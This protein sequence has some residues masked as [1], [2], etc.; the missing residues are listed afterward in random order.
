M[1]VSMKTLKILLVP[2]V[3]VV[4]LGG[5]RIA[6]GER[7]SGRG[8]ETAAAGR[9]LREATGGERTEM[10]SNQAAGEIL[11]K[12][13]PGLTREAVD[14]I[15]QEQGLRI[16]RLVSPPAL[17]LLEIRDAVSAE[18]M[19]QRIQRLVEVEYAEPNYTRR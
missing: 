13:K 9:E 2:A 17:Y 10:V 4:L 14:R 18:E 1:K 5:C 16:V 11:V 6:A 8:P 12:F 3:L 19:I 15:A 7:F